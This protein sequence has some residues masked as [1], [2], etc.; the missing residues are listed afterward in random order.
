M[1]IFSCMPFLWKELNSFF[2]SVFHEEIINLVRKKINFVIEKSIFMEFQF[3]CQ[4]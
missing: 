3:I 2:A 1:E 4:Q